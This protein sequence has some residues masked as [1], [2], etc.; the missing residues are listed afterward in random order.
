MKE[1]HPRAPLRTLA[2]VC[3]ILDLCSVIRIEVAMFAKLDNQANNIM[4]ATIGGAGSK[5]LSGWV[6]QGIP[7]VKMKA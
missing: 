5:Q 7:R 4:A 1:V 6:N 3:V 2:L